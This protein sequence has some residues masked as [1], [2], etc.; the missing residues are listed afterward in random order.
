MDDCVSRC[1]MG[2]E[3]GQCLSVTRTARCVCCKQPSRAR[4]PFRASTCMGICTGSLTRNVAGC[5]P[6]RRSLYCLDSSHQTEHGTI[7]HL[8]NVS[9]P[10]TPVAV[11]Q[12]VPITM[13]M[14]LNRASPA[15]LD[16]RAMDD[17]VTNK[18]R[19]HRRE[20]SCYCGRHVPLTPTTKYP[21][22]RARSP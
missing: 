12:P 19:R 22:P 16:P 18:Q 7:A 4:H 10:S 13:T 14:T 21:Y 15:V 2:A 6:V 11:Q 3:V 5:H 9:G 8:S 20:R 17:M 1:I